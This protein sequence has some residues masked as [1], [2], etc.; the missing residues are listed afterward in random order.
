MSARGKGAEAL[1][2]LAIETLKAEIN[3]ALP[4]DKR[5][6]AAMIANALEIAR[7]E[8]EAAEDG[9][10]FVL[11]DAFYEDGDGTLKQLASDIRKGEIGEDKHPDLRQRLRTHLIAELKIRN[12]RFLKSRGVKV[13]KTQLLMPSW[14]RLFPQ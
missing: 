5:Y 8:V 9:Q 14:A 2:D 13:W 10:E 4:A 7:R 3:P 12:P 1:L 6:A 11:L